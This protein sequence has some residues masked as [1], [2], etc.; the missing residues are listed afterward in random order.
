MAADI[1]RRT[2]PGGKLALNVGIPNYAAV[3]I[4]VRSAI[5]STESDLTPPRVSKASRRIARVFSAPERPTPVL[6]IDDADKWAG[7]PVPGDE[8][9]RARLLFT[10][11]LQPLLT[12]QLHLVVAVQQH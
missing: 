2:G 9:K 10:S 5:K 8:D 7:S 1:T 3:S 6:I 4:E 11:A 12:L